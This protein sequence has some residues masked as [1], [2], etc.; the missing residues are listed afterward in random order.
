M[1]SPKLSAR[2]GRTVLLLLSLLVALFAGMAAILIHLRTGQAGLEQEAQPLPESSRERAELTSLEGPEEPLEPAEEGA[3]RVAVDQPSSEPVPSPTPSEGL[4]GTVYCSQSSEA[5]P[6]YE[7]SGWVNDGR[8]KQ[9]IGLK[10]DA[11]GKFS[12]PQVTEPAK[13]RLRLVPDMKYPNRSFSD[14]RTLYFDPEGEVSE[15]AHE[16]YGSEG[17]GR[18]GPFDIHVASGPTCFFD[19]DWPVGY[20]A[21]DFQVQITRARPV[22]TSPWTSKPIHGGLREPSAAHLA[23]P[24]LPWARFPKLHWNDG[25]WV[26]LRSTDQV[27][28]GGAAIERTFGTE[29]EPLKITFSRS[30]SLTGIFDMPSLDTD[31]D[32]VQDWCELRLTQLPSPLDL[33]GAWT[34][35]RG[36]HAEDGEPFFFEF[37][38]PGEYLLSTHDKGWKPWSMRITIAPGLNDIGRRE[39]EP[40]PLIGAIRG[41]IVSESGS[42]E[43]GCHVS[44]HDVAFV[45]DALY[46]HSL[47]WYEDEN[48]QLYADIEFEDVRAGEWKLFVHCHDGFEWPLS[49]R[50]IQAPADGV[51]IELLDRRMDLAVEIQDSVTGEAVEG[52]SFTWRIGEEQRKVSGPEVR[53]SNLPYRPDDFEY[54]AEAEGYQPYRGTGTDFTTAITTGGLT[55]LVQG[56]VKMVRGWGVRVQLY[57]RERH[58][59]IPGVSVIAEGLERGKTNE[60]GLFDLALES[61]PKSLRFE[62]DGWEFVG[63]PI[64]SLQDRTNRAPGRV[65]LLPMK[66]T[67]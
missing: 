48:G 58:G 15:A 66:K 55:T 30:T 34:E 46:D 56:E 9:A 39:L 3:L 59:R 41:R 20:D 26:E 45:H 42:Y 6:E 7:L 2:S 29:P 27:Y 11:A 8:L 13:V 63:D 10:T 62:K 43:G 61:A 53:K 54:W 25:A 32:Y 35:K 24:E 49:L 52:S 51:L 22:Q 47:D 4:T 65:L 23:H 1:K 5:L 38:D 31:P 57:D 14:F 44:L 37:L 40:R 18:P 19:V 60:E 12:L 17:D 67:E 16:A 21:H 64:S 28:R 36:G 33:P 50:T